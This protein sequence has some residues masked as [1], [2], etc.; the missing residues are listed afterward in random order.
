MNAF[1]ILEAERR[2]CCC[3]GRTNL[4]MLLMGIQKASRPL[5]AFYAPY[6]DRGSGA[7]DFR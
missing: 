6:L 3:M 5:G 4:L 1:N 2:K 7:S